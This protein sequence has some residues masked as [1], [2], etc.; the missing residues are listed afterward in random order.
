MQISVCTFGQRM[1]NFLPIFIVAGLAYMLVRKGRDLADQLEINL[2]DAKIDKSKTTIS[3]IQGTIKIDI[4][5]PTNTGF[6]FKGLKADAFYKKNRVAKIFWQQKVTV[7]PNQTTSIVIP[8]TIP[9]SAFASSLTESIL[10]YL[11]YK[12]LPALNVAGEVFFDSGSLNIN[13]TISIK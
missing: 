5:N 7:L 9:V 8:V 12:A 10:D 11:E 1:K 4:L 3:R 6:S 2:T 13:K